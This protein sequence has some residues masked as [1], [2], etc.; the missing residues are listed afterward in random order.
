MT[1]RVQSEEMNMFRRSKADIETKIIGCTHTTRNVNIQLDA[2]AKAAAFCRM[3]RGVY[4]AG[5]VRWSDPIGYNNETTAAQQ[6][7]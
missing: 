2:E 5:T 3:A 1:S 7:T 6:L 4:S